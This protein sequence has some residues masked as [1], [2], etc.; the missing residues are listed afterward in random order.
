M[1]MG[2]PIAFH[3]Q[4]FKGRALLLSTYEKELF[5]LVSA[6]QKWRP[7][8]LGR[9]FVVKT[10]QRSLK[11]LLDHKVGTPHTGKMGYQVAGI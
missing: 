3:S 6:I 10:D 2:R 8:L 1:K 7:Y 5:V 4:A 9:A 11:Y